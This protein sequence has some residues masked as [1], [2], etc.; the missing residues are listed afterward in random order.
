MAAKKDSMD[1]QLVTVIEEKRAL[2]STERDLTS[3]M[4]SITYFSYSIDYT[5]IR[6]FLLN[7]EHD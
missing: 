5:Y 7:C 3:K 2:L 1:A 4:V 6:I